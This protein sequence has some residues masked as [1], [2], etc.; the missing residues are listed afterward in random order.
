MISNSVNRFMALVLLIGLISCQSDP[1]NKGYLI[2]GIV[3]GVPDST[4]V[5]LYLFPEKDIVADSAIVI[6]E[7]FQFKG[8]ISRPR[9]AH[10]RI[11]ESRDSRTFW[12]ENQ[13][14]DIIGQKGNFIDSKISGSKTQKESELL[15]NRKDSIFEEMKRL[16]AQVTES[17]RDSLFVIYEQMQEVE[18]K[19]NKQFI[20]D[21]PHSYESLTRLNW[22]KERMGSEQ[23]AEVFSHLSLEL[24]GTDEGIA[25]EEFIAKNKSL[26]IGDQFVDFEQPDINQQVVKFSDMKKKYTLL[27]FWASWCGPCRGSNPELVELYKKYN[28]KGFEILGVSFDSNQEKWQNAI[29]Q[30][31]LLW[32]NVSDLK[33]TNNEAAM[34]YGVRDIPDNF[35]I[36]ENGI[37]ISRF[38]RGKELEIKLNELFD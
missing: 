26:R 30:D 35:L 32:I 31:G 17:N 37:I 20:R 11:I 34:I 28:N 16:E 1:V 12:L 33:G 29:E 15:L 9:L 25:I 10:L 3:K 5:L 21:Y 6:N 7:K 13:K 2:N 8:N 24:Q 27:E 22:S 38:I 4:K 36:D 19:I 23:T 18:I 14:I